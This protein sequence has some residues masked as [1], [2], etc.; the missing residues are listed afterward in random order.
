MKEE[1]LAVIAA[2]VSRAPDWIRRDLSSTNLASRQR[3][4]EALAAMPAAAIKGAD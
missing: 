4:E 1:Q 3:A 2:V